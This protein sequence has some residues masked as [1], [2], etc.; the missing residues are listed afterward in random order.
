MDERYI[1]WAEACKLQREIYRDLQERRQ[2]ARQAEAD[3]WRDTDE[4]PP[5]LPDREDK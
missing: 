1:T 2:R 5:T 3:Y 4:D